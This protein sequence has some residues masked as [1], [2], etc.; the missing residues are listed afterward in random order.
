MLFLLCLL[1]SLLSCNHSPAVDNDKVVISNQEDFYEKM[2]I[3]DTACISATERAEQ[4]YK[5][6][7]RPISRHVLYHTKD[8]TPNELLA[9]EL[10]KI[11]LSL[12]LTPETDRFDS[13][14]HLKI[15]REN[16]YQDMMRRLILNDL[17]NKIIDSVSSL[18]SKKYLEQ[19]PETIINRQD[20]D[21]GY[22]SAQAHEFTSCQEKFKLSFE[23][24][25]RYPEGYKKTTER[26]SAT[27]VNILILKN[28]DLKDITITP[29]FSISSNEAYKNYFVEQ[30]TGIIKKIRWTP[31]ICESIPVNA[32]LDFRLKHY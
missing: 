30:I 26:T 3:T 22:E 9:N 13:L 8:F 27:Q 32:S 19:N 6:G 14:G 16:C 7:K 4:D 18:A 31:P 17:D 5:N 29:E 20:L 15:F 12:D 11:N 25:F 28:G 23:F 10:R 1:H 24:E 2:K 21:Y